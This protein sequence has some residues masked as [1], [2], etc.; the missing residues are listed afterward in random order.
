LS[1]TEYVA[2]VLDREADPNVTEAARALAVTARSWV[3][4]NAAF[5]KGCWHVEDSTRMQRVSAR[6]ATAAARNVSLF[7][8]GL[9][10][11]GAPVR[12]QRDGAE[13][14]VLAWVDA[15]GQA[16]AGARFDR[17][18]ADAFSGGVLA[19]ESGEVECRRLPDVEHWLAAA[20]S[21]WQRRLAREPGFEPLDRLTVC[22]LDHGDPYSDRER[23]RMYVRGLGSADN[24]NTLAHEYV[25]LAFRFHPT[26]QDEAS[27]ER[28]AR[29]LTEE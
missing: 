19:A 9:V 12:Y 3:V 6:P 14:G 16:R 15:V 17:I 23:M 7:A 24:R 11:Q 22:A 25:H 26:G 29:R 10:V 13:P 21:R 8:S 5:E 2:R 18:L 28:L 20:T 27:V 1:L 4:Q